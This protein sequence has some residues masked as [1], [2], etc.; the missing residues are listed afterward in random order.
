MA[1][2]LKKLTIRGY[3]SIETLKDFPMGRL[4]VLIGANGAG[5]SNFVDFF[6]LLRAIADERL[7]QFVNE[8]GGGDGFFFLGPKYTRQIG[9]RLEFGEH[10][11]EFE[12]EPTADG[13]VQ[14]SDERVQSAGG[15]GMG[16]LRS[17]GKGVRESQLKSRKDEPASF[18]RGR[19]VPAHVHDSVSSWT[20]YHFH[21]TG[22]L[23]PMRRD[24]LVRDRGLL[25]PDASNLAALLLHLR[26]TT[27]SCY[28]QILET[29]HLIAPFLDDFIL[30]P[31]IRGGEEKIRLEWRQKGSDYPFQP[32]QLSDGT[33]RFICLATALLQPRRP[34]TIVVDEPELG[35]HPCA[36]RLLAE[37]IQS[38]SEHTQVVVSTQS[39]YLLDQFRPEDLVVVTRN[40]GRSA[41]TRLR[42]CELSE[43]LQEYSLGELWQKNVLRGSPTN[44]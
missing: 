12:L 1:S 37:L 34:A 38:A 27:P 3:K 39:P 7:Q 23:A 14:I 2:A 20:V 35:L 30:Q 33:I 18:G 42:P 29:V 24:Q 4:T 6:R 43:W 26:N 31:E 32:S 19:G 44:D 41:F 5:K 36:I 28:Q 17:I 10:V 21:D 9:V 25:R 22:M 8:Q 40:E 15:H 16:G 13:T 11:Y